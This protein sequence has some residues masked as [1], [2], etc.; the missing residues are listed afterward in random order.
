MTYEGTWGL[1]R[2]TP[3][4]RDGWPTS[5]HMTVRLLSLRMRR[6]FK[7]N[8][9]LCCFHLLSRHAVVSQ[10]TC[11]PVRGR[12]SFYHRHLTSTSQIKA[13]I[14]QAA[15]M[16]PSHL[17]RCCRIVWHVTVQWLDI[18]LSTSSIVIVGISCE[19]LRCCD[20][21]GKVDGRC[22]VTSPCDNE[23]TTALWTNAVLA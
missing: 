21:N 2:S 1:P 9:V 15:Y 10:I 22:H 7:C 3:C 19:L 13:P 14:I 11:P 18:V 17:C 23:Q 20:T 6:N 12:T 5:S 8:Y 16:A 4:S